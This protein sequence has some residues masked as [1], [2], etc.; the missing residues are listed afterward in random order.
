MPADR[1]RFDERFDFL[2]HEHLLYLR[3]KR[4][5][6]L[7]IVINVIFHIFQALFIRG[8]RAASSERDGDEEERANST[9][10]RSVAFALILGNLVTDLWG[11]FVMR[12]NSRLL[13]DSYVA[14]QAAI[15]VLAGLF[16]V[17]P[18]IFLRVICLLFTLQIR[19]MMSE[20]DLS[21]LAA[22]PMERILAQP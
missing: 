22:A 16:S 14:L 19:K 2:T 13:V 12:R 7:I 21:I 5:L 11:L 18:A 17:S 8:A 1:A 3:R 10:L 9:S 20:L 4:S 6:M 15:V